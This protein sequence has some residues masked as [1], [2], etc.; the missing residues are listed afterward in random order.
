MG[1]ECCF[2]EERI[3][4]KWANYVFLTVTGMKMSKCGGAN[5]SVFWYNS[6]VHL[7]K[8]SRYKN[9]LVPGRRVKNLGLLLTVRNLAIYHSSIC[10]SDLTTL[11]VSFQ[12]GCWDEPFL[13]RSWERSIESNRVWCHWI[14][15]RTLLFITMRI[16]NY[17]VFIDKEWQSHRASFMDNLTHL[18]HPDSAKDRH[19]GLYGETYTDIF[20]NG[21]VVKLL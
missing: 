13:L 10:P 7:R 18:A 2:G 5:F 19:N 8:S 14:D 1:N 12:V 16:R 20:L 9:L 15:S 21:H 11:A 6:L 3:W 4:G 17:S